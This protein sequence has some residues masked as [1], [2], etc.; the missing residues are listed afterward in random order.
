ML[1]AKELL[2][3]LSQHLNELAKNFDYFFLNSKDPRTGILW[4]NNIFIEDV[5]KW[6]VHLC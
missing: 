2:D 5:N 4:M 1:K 6:K 3:I